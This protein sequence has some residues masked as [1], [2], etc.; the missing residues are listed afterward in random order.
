[1]NI[2]YRIRLYVAAH[3]IGTTV[4]LTVIWLLT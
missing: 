3:V 4:T 2:N 1:M